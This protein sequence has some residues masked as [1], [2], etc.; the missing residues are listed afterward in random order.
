MFCS[1]LWPLLLLLLMGDMYPAVTAVV[2]A[3]A[4]I[5]AGQAIWSIF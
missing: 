1:L 2:A 5:A 3:S 4:Y